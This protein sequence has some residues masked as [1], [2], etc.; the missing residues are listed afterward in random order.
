MSFPHC[1]FP[2]TKMLFPLTS[3]A[4]T[5]FL[6][7]TSPVLKIRFTDAPSHMR[8]SPSSSTMRSPSITQPRQITPPYRLRCLLHVIQD[9]DRYCLIQQCLSRTLCAEEPENRHR[10]LPIS[11]SMSRFLP[12]AVNLVQIFS[13]LSLKVF[14]T[15][16]FTYILISILPCLLYTSPSPRD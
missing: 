12:Y 1:I 15:I 13:Y 2:R 7:K 4:E 16:P 11:R 9:R 10:F 3:A 14:L 5:S 8:S 6:R